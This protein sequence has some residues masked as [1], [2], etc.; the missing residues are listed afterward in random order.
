MLLALSQLV[1]CGGQLVAWPADDI[2]PPTVIST[3]PE[4]DALGVLLNRTLT[5]TFSEPMDPDTLTMTSFAVFDGATAVPGTVS[6]SGVSAT[7]DPDSDLE[8][9]TTYTAV[10]RESATDVAGNPLAADYTWTFTTGGS[11]DVQRPVVTLTIPE[12]DA[13]GVSPDASLAAVFSEAMDPATFV[14]ATLTLTEGINPVVGT[15]TLTGATAMFDPSAVL[16]FGTEYTAIISVVAADL[17]GNTLAAEHRWTFTTADAVVLVPPRVTL[18]HPANLEAAVPRDT[19]VSAAFSQPMTPLTAMNSLSVTDPLGASVP[20][21]L[22]YDM[23]TQ[24]V[25]FVPT[26]LLAPITEY[27]ATVAVSATNLAGTPLAAEHMWTFS[28]G[29]AMPIAPRVILTNPLPFEAGVPLLTTVSAAFN[30]LMDP[31]TPVGSFTLTDE[32]GM[33]VTG[34]GVYDALSQTLTFTPMNPLLADT[35][36]TARVSTAATNMAGT[37]L[38]ADYIWEFTTAMVVAPRVITTS[39]V[40]LDTGVLR[41]AIITATFS[42]PMNPLTAQSSFSVLDPSGDTVVGT[43]SFDAPSQ[44]LFFVPDDF[45]QANAT[46][47]ATVT[48]VATSVVGTPL[49]ADYEWEFTTGIQAA[50]ML[51]V[52]LRSLV[53]FVAAAGAGLTNSN[54]SGMTLLGGD[55]ALSPT[56]TCIGDGLPCTLLNPQITGT[57]Y[58]PGLIAATAKSDLLLAYTDATSRP[59]GTLVNDIS[60]LVL[61]AGVYTSASTMSIAVGGTVTLDG[62]GD[63]NAVFIFQVGSSLTANNDAQVVLINGARARN[64]FWAIAASSTL[65]S[66]VAFQGSVMAGASNSVGTDSSVVGRLLCT[67]GQITLLSNTITLPL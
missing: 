45:L 33:L 66:N 12:D 46:Y 14:G 47:T 24:T 32:G 3:A 67:T 31:L 55:V 51:P 37:S 25:T 2:T 53:S 26:S 17:A 59:P 5:V 48:T 10:V 52:D 7:F 39:P 28:T 20:G 8:S 42:E 16:A 63:P 44:T 13:T 1:G 40:D 49:T 4:R 62:G 29:P 22:A 65:G 57:L 38:A 6:Y 27:T 56:G 11:L 54:S 21:S 34:V 35:T 64:V 23:V 36:Y 58:G 18:T 9:G 61:P 19:T 50:G 15:V 41:D 43:L 30:Q 60:G